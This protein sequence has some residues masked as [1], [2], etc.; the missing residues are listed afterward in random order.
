MLQG[1]LRGRLLGGGLKSPWISSFMQ[2]S[3]CNSLAIK[4]SLNELKPPSEGKT[5]EFDEL[6]TSSQELRENRTKATFFDIE[7]LIAN[8]PG[9][10]ETPTFHDKFDKFSFGSSLRNPREVAKSINMFGPPAGRSVDVRSNLGSAL[11][12]LRHV[13][14]KDKI[15]EYQ[16]IQARYI[17]PA[18]LRKM[19]MAYWWKRNFRE[20]FHHLM[21]DIKDAKRRGY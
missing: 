10:Q 14:K 9:L 20:Q 8:S 17:R 18:K 11:L 19:K 1:H 3:F 7:S 15:K 21:I 12:G 5:T 4:S 6:K 16:Q 2:R 13:L